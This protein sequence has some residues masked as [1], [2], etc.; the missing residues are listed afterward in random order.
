L[1]QKSHNSLWAA[2]GR[3]KFATGKAVGPGLGPAL[4]IAL[5]DAAAAGAHDPTESNTP[6]RLTQFLPSIV[7]ERLY[8]FPTLQ[9]EVGGRF[10]DRNW[11]SLDF[12]A[13]RLAPYFL[14]TAT[15]LEL[16]QNYERTDG[17]A[18]LGAVCFF[19]STTVAIVHSC[20]CL[21]SVRSTARAG[22]R[23]GCGCG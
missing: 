14:D 4:L 9:D 19:V 20:T 6:M 5:S 23:L 17:P 2:K 13:G 21:R 12:F 3:R 7:R 18:V 10:P 22:K 15:L 16:G 1:Y 11:T 8:T